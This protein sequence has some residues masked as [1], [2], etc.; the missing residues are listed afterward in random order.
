MNVEQLNQ[1]KDVVFAIT[2][3]DGIMLAD[4]DMQS[5]IEDARTIQNS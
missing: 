5:Y 1:H 2:D 4:I 3:G